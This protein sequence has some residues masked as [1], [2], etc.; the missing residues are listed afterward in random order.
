M[1]DF[2]KIREEPFEYWR[3]EEFESFNFWLRQ[4]YAV[5]SE[6]L[7]ALEPG[8]KLKALRHAAILFKTGMLFS[9]PNIGVNELHVAPGYDRDL[10]EFWAYYT[11]IKRGHAQAIM[12]SYPFLRVRDKDAHD[13]K[14]RKAKIALLHKYKA[15]KIVP[16]LSRENW[17]WKKIRRR[18][19]FGGA[20]LA[21]IGVTAGIV[22]YGK[23]FKENAAQV[24]C[25]IQHRLDPD[26]CRPAYLGPVDAIAKPEDMQALRIPGGR[27]A[28][29]G[30][31]NATNQN[32]DATPEEAA[33]EKERLANL[34]RS[35]DTTR[36]SPEEL[37]AATRANPVTA[38]MTRTTTALEGPQDEAKRIFPPLPADSEIK[39]IGTDPA[40]KKAIISVP[41]REGLKDGYVP[42]DAI[43]RPSAPSSPAPRPASP[44]GPENSPQ[45]APR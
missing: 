11:Q 15:G 38:R 8:E 18:L 17:T 9:H 19:V 32:P 2:T 6:K 43:G 33:R 40:A 23:Q 29:P 22:T 26:W 20:G 7:D 42:L 41:T 3:P 12:D 44:P 28:Q 5:F 35:R 39:V 45:P 34:T 24:T 30:E 4:N 10:Q 31:I 14:L 25:Q 21:A 1:V 37:A 27:A 36:I 16:L 13:A